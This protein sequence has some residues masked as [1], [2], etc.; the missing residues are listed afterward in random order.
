MTLIDFE[1]MDDGVGVITFNRPEKRN[2]FNVAMRGELMD[3][4]RGVAVRDLTCVIL[5]GAGKGFSA[6]ADLR[7]VSDPSTWPGPAPASQLFRAVREADPVVIAAVHGAALGLGSG[8]AMAADLVVAARS[9]VFGYPEVQH[10]LLAGL[11]AVGLKELVT[12]RVAKELLVT[13]RSVDADEAARLGMVNEV[14]DDE[15]L[16]DRALALAAG[17]SA[18]SAAA[19]KSTKRLFTELDE[20]GH[21]AGMEHAERV[22][23]DVRRSADAQARSASFFVRSEKG[24]S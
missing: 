13:G 21:A 1:A 22:V 3:V 6:G 10:G 20:L 12:R 24:T 17:I 14:V 7:E 8:L 11:T 23:G 19:V 2:A 5:R 15:E 18:N 16:M 9:A 4:M